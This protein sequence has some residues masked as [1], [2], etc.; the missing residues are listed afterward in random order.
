MREYLDLLSYVRDNG[1]W[2]PT[3]AVLASTGQPARAR[4]YFGLQARYDLGGGFPLVT[5]REISFT[6]VVR[7]LLWFLS[8]SGNRLALEKHGIRIWSQWGHEDGDLGAAIYGRLWRGSRYGDQIATLEHRI[9]T[10]SAEPHSRLRRRLILLSW[11]PPYSTY[12]QAPVGCHTMAQ[13]DVRDGRLSCHLYQRSGDLF[14]GVPYNIAS[15]ALLTHLLAHVTGLQLGVL[16]H[17]FGDAHIYENHLEQVNEQLCRPPRHRPQLKLTR[18][19][20]SVTE[21]LFEDI[22]LSG[23]E[24]HPKLTGEVAV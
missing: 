23:Y 8:G 17:S 18:E 22:L 11:D 24:C 3:G 6:V 19:V 2:Q 12:S 16:V 14:L 13:F 1:Q 21:F 7:E 9:R 10:V 20:A 15:Y 4:S 5:T